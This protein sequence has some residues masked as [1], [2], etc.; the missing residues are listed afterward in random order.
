MLTGSNVASKCNTTNAWTHLRNFH[1]DVI[2]KID[3]AREK[4]NVDPKD[5]KISQFFGK[6]GDVPKEVLDDKVISN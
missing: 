6:K 3:A 5:K 2:S 1:P 4:D